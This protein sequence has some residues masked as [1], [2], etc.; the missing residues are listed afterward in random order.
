[1]FEIERLGKERWLE[2][3]P[4]HCHVTRVSSFTC[5]TAPSSSIGRKLQ[6]VESILFLAIQLRE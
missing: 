4:L 1:V 6:L 5:E 2:R 3:H